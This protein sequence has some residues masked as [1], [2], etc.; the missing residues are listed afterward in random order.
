[1]K[2]QTT[3]GFQKLEYTTAKITKEIHRAIS[4]EAAKQGKDKQEL[5]N[6]VI[7]AGMQKMDIPLSV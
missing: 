2:K 1:M 4:V 7:R 6:A 5:F 3:T